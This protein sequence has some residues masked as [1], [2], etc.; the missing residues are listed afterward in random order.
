MS[1][2]FPLWGVF[3]TEKYCDSRKLHVNCNTTILENGTVITFGGYGRGSIEPN[4]DVAGIGV[5][6]PLY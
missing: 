3:E 1:G 4:V 2:L 6:F 5:G